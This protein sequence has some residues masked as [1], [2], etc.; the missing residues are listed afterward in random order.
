MGC[1]AWDDD[2]I[3]LHAEFKPS[4]LNTLVYLI[5][6]GMETVTLAV[7]YTG[8]P[9][10]ESLIENKPML[11]SLIVAVLGIVILP[12][13]PFA[14]ALQLVHLDYDL[15]IMFF[16]VLAFDFIASFLIDRVLVFIFGRV[17]QKS[18]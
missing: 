6:T 9:F 5:S 14:D 8:H 3:D 16:K 10:M 2:F 7:N 4:V 17:K 1:S 11:I 12:F 13:G 15:R 18:L